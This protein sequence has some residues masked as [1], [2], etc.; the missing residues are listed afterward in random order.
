MFC[1]FADGDLAA[2]RSSH[3]TF[4]CFIGQVAISALIHVEK[5]WLRK[6]EWKMWKSEKLPYMREMIYTSLYTNGNNISNHF[7]QP[8]LVFRK[9]GS[10][11]AS[12]VNGNFFYL[13]LL[14][15]LQF[16]SLCLIPGPISTVN[17]AKNL[18]MIV[19][20][21]LLTSFRFWWKLNMGYNTAKPFV[22]LRVWNVSF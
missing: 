12:I 20:M 8:C 17:D 1:H 19:F 10:R 3:N 14:K 13:N 5:I 21:Q 11:S 22:I 4:S 6:R 18:W 16:F 7:C 9:I 2:W 15:A